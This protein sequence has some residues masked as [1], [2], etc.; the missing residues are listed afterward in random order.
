MNVEGAGG[1]RQRTLWGFVAFCLASA[2]VGVAGSVYATGWP[3]LL[4]LWVHDVAAYLVLVAVA[5]VTKAPRPKAASL[6]HAGWWLAVLF[7]TAPVS[8]AAVGGSLGSS[9]TTLVF[10]L[11]PFLTVFMVAQREGAELTLLAPAVVTL[12]GLA[13]VVPF[14]WHGSGVGFGSLGVMVLCAG[15]VAFA[16]IRLHSLLQEVPILWAAALGS[17]LSAA[18]GFVAWLIFERGTVE[19]VWSAVCGEVAWGVLIDAPLVLLTVWLLKRMRAEGF[20]ARFAVVPML[21]V[22]AGILVMRS[23]VVW[24]TWLGLGLVLGG[25]WLLVREV[26]E[27]AEDLSKRAGTG[28]GA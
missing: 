24:T 21:S 9:A 12:G 3:S 2:V 15:L 4:R 26:T 10:G 22:F 18:L 23:A 7:V 25:S 17:G 16:G 20:A 8:Y 13:L 28:D 27:V 1:K 11:I 19:W 5:L 14:A 6:G